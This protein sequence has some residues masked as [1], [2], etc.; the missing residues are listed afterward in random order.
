MLAHNQDSSTCGS[1]MKGLRFW[2]IYCVVAVSLLGTEVQ[3]KTKVDF[4]GSLFP[5]YAIATATLDKERVFGKPTAT[6]LGDTGGMFGIELVAPQDNAKFILEISSPIFVRKT[7]MQG[8]LQKKD[9]TYRIY[10]ELDYDYEALYSVKEPQPEALTFRLEINGEDAGFRRV[11][12]QVRSI[13]DCLY[14]WSPS[15]DRPPQIYQWMFAAYV[16]ENDPLVDKILQRAL[17]LELV[18][19]FIGYQG[20]ERDVYEQ[21]FAVWNVLQREGIKYSNITTTS[22]ESAVAHSQH[23]RLIDESISNTQANCVDGSVLF[24][25]VFRKIGLETF[26]FVIPGHCFVGVFLDQKMTKPLAIETTRIGTDDLNK[27]GIER[28]LNSIMSG[29]KNNLSWTSFEGAHN[30]GAQ[31]FNHSIQQLK[32]GQFGYY[33]I[34][35]R[36]T[37][38]VGIQPL[39]SRK[40]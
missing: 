25:S 24:A 39:R 38:E 35:I 1:Y 19:S 21:V 17:Q 5:S 32:L 29:R 15:P 14:A 13:N 12:V 2:A 18:K 20:T 34:P 3:W 8:V 6:Y 31:E 40:R 26:L 11:T 22:S 33:L 37:R 16:N 30:A 23:V 27:Q 4:G 28:G 7:V 9:S 10:P 36:Q